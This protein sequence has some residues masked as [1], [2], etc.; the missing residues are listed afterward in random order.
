MVSSEVSQNFWHRDR[1]G[2][3]AGREREKDPKIFVEKGGIGFFVNIPGQ[4]EAIVFTTSHN[5]IDEN[6]KI[7]QNL[8]AWSSDLGEQH[9][10]GEILKPD[11]RTSEVFST[12]P[13]EQS[14]I[15]D[16]GILMIPKSNNP[17]P[18]R[19]AFEFAMRLAEEERLE[20]I[21]R[22]SSYLTTAK[23]DKPPTRIAERIFSPILK[24]HQLEYLIWRLV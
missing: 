13:N 7:T 16:F 17:P 4:K 2:G 20:G 11:T 3:D 18:P 19:T 15:D 5:F 22:I 14:A 12:T 24:Q 6:V 8:R 9:K 1:R 23:A 10:G 21:C